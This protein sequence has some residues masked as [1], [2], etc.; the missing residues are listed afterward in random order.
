[1]NLASEALDKQDVKRL[2]SIVNQLY[3]LLIVK[4]K[5]T[6]KDNFTDGN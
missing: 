1:M 5:D 3:S 4:P 2:K 6:D